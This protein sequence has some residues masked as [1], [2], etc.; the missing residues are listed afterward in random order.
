MVFFVQ[1]KITNPVK[2]PIYKDLSRDDLLNRCLGSHMQNNEYLM[3][4]LK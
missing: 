2:K 3:Q 1:R 4:N